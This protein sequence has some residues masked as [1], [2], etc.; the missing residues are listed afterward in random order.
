MTKKKVTA[1]NRL[2]RKHWLKTIDLTKR[3]Y[4]YRNLHKNCWSVRQ[5]GK[6]VDHTHFLL[7][8]DCR[9][10]V[11]KAGRKRVLREHKK[12][13]HAGVSGYVTDKVPEEQ[14]WDDWGTVVYNPYDHDQFYAG[15]F[16]VSNSHYCIF[17]GKEVEAVW[18]NQY[19]YYE[20]N[21]DW[22]GT[23]K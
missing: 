16:P 22:K 6:V 17:N 21:R 14:F 20:F 13:V 5:S 7:L 9:Y 19:D 12:N 2:Y 15:S 3:V 23:F 8:K 1:G 4:V 11:G 18:E 10:L